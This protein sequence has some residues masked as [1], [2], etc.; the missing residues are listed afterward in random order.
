LNFTAICGTKLFWYSPFSHDEISEIF[1][2][3]NLPTIITKK[4]V[5]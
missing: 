5:L 4:Y 2:D 3:T 1:Q